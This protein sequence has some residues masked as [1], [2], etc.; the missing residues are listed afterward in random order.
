MITQDQWVLQVIQSYQT[1]FVTPPVQQI[2]PHMSNL[3]E[4]QERLLA[5]E[6]EEL[7]LKDAINPV[8]ELLGGGINKFYICGIKKDGAIDRW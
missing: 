1:E 8:V 4:M 6:V 7:L 5:L 2:L 3:P